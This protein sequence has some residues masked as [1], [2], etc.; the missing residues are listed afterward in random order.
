[1]STADEKEAPRGVNQWGLGRVSDLNPRETNDN[2]N[3]N[4]VVALQQAIR[5]RSVKG[6]E[7]H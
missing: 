3:V 6:T 1:M 2:I 4:Q 7:S 5:R